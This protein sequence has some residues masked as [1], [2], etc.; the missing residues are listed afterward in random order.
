MQVFF[1]PYVAD[2]G[3]ACVYAIKFSPSRQELKALVNKPI[4]WHALAGLPTR[5]LE[6]SYGRDCNFAQEPEPQ[7]LYINEDGDALNAAKGGRLQVQVCF[8]AV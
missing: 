6:R 1:R 8:A 5:P 3:A 7:V 2:T 4:A